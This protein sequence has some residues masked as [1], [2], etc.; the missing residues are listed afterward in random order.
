MRVRGSDGRD[1][2]LHL[3]TGNVRDE[4]EQTVVVGLPRRGGSDALTLPFEGDPTLV[5]I[6]ARAQALVRDAAGALDAG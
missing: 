3:G 4:D 2:E 5:S 1:Y 6:L